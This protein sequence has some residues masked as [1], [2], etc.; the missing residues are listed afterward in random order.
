MMSAPSD[1]LPDDVAAALARTGVAGAVVS[2]TALAGGVS[3]EI[4]HVATTSG[5][6]C[7]KRALAV[8]RTSDHWEA[9]VERSTSEARWLELAARLVPDLAPRLLAVDH[10]TGTLV[11]E[12]L[13]SD[14]YEVWKTQLLGGHVS[15]DTASALARG[16]RRFHDRAAD[17]LLAGDFD[18]PELI[19][20]LRL[21]PYLDRTAERHRDLAEAIGRLRLEFHEHARTV[22]HGDVS[23]KN[24]LVAG[25]RVVLLDAECATW[26]D[27][28]FD[29]AFCLTH[30]CAKA[31]HLRRLGGRWRPGADAFVGS[32]GARSPDDDERCARWLAVLLLAR[33][34]GASPLEYLDGGARERVRQ[35]ARHLV[36]APT[37]GVT[38][39]IDRWFAMLVDDAAQA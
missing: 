15:V 32:Y 34:D 18:R 30:L 39:A 22:V 29:V 11:L 25:D 6:V 26:G 21:E 36:G 2:S 24:V 31:H 16:L 1:D 3:S 17:P 23:P 28:M 19:A 27:P 13:D 10:D 5:D 20:A 35:G 33:V 4:W 9:P 12:Y 8:L 38:E 7:V 37:A 14:R